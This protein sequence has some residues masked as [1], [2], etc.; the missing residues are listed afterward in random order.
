MCGSWTS[1]RP[2]EIQRLWVW[3]ASAE[4][5]AEEVGGLL[6]AFLEYVSVKVQRGSS[7]GM[8]EPPADGLG[9]N[10]GHEQLGGVCASQ[11]MK[12]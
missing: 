2:E 9:W 7:H 10:A 5:V 11:I 4:K 8:T 6:V 12:A 3:L 1:Q